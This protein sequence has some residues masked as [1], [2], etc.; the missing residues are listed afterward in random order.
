MGA[1]G[2]TAGAWTRG[3]PLLRPGSLAWLVAHDLRIGWRGASAVLG[4][5]RPA[6]LW[7]VLAAGALVLHALAWPVAG[8]LSPWVHGGQDD[9]PLVTVLVCT[10]AWLMAQALFSASRTLYS[11]GDLDLLLGAPLPA[12]RVFAAKAAS[13]AAGSF[14][15]IALLVLPIANMGALVDRP[16]WLGLYPALAG[17]ALIATAMGLATTIAL[18]TVLG[19]RRA[20]VWT[21]MTGAVIAGSFVLGAQIAAVL[22]AS[23]RE[24][25]RASIESMMAGHGSFL[26][27]LLRLPL[28]TVRGEAGA[29]LTLMVVALVMM[30]AAT[31]LLGRRFADASVSA[32]GAAAHASARAGQP[33]RFRAGL[34]RN[35]RRKEWR[36]L[37]RDP[38]TFAQL[39]L[40]IIYTIPI[41]IVL[42][43]SES[44]PPILALAPTIVV[45][46]AQVA[47]SLAW[48]TVSGEDAPELIATAPV[49][50]TAV[51]RAKLTSIALPVGVILALPLAGLAVISWQSALITAVVAAAAATSTALLNFWHPMPGNRRGMLRRHQ[52]SKLVALMEHG[53]A[54]LWALAVILAVLGSLLALVPAALVAGVF[55]LVRRGRHRA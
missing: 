13:I 20:R 50:A 48:L 24:A 18:F 47:A 27:P 2:A 26:M 49:D 38:G 11:R 41:A 39:S 53:L 42:L 29:G 51:D 25:L 45:V 30:S 9:G 46:A 4:D 1:A 28:D 22:P 12:H 37:A 21:Q 3:V 23:I 34:A 36:L 6:V 43:R 54:L 5:A 16:A 14:G 17:M 33:V 10:F 40:Q 44:L 15:S 31:L 52:Q 55:V 7:S 32:A 19:P 35:L 8:W